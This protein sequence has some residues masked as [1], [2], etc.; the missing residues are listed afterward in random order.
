MKVPADLS[1]LSG[2]RQRWMQTYWDI[3][4]D[5]L[6]QST[7]DLRL[8]QRIFT[9][10]N[11]DSKYTAKIT[12]EWLW[13]HSVN[14]WPSQWLAGHWCAPSIPIQ[15][16][17]FSKQEWK[18]CWARGIILKKTWGC[19]WGYQKCFKYWAKAFNSYMHVLCTFSVFSKFKRIP[20][21]VFAHFVIMGTVCRT[22]SRAMNLLNVEKDCNMTK[23][24]TS[25]NSISVKG[26][27]LYM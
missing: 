17:R 5:N 14:E 22:F 1:D 15:L 16:E 27:M 3:L 10:T 8:E 26:N 6:L 18:V 25:N 23:F 20:S 21:K 9:Q 2:S 13:D 12:K 7:P 19:H 4:D 24:G 11:N